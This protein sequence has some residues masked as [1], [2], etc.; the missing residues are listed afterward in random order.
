MTMRVEGSGVVLDC[1]SPHLIG[2]DALGTGMALYYL[3]VNCV[4]LNNLSDWLRKGQVCN[5]W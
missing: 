5:S 1:R 3:K 4:S 2:T